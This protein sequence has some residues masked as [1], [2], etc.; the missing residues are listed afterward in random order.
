[1]QTLEQAILEL[2]QAWE[3]DA[4][5]DGEAP[6]IIGAVDETFLERLLLVFLDL[7]TGYLLLEEAVE[8]R[9]Y[10]TWKGLVDKRLETLGAP[11]RYLVSDRAKALIQL[12]E[13]G[14]E[15]LSIPDVFHLVHEIVKSYSLAIGRQLR[16][17]RQEWQ[18]AQD[19]LQKHQELE[20]RCPASP[21]ATCQVEATQA[22]VR[23][24]EAAQSEYRQ[25]LEILS[26]TLHPL[27]LDDSAPQTSTQVESRV[28]A[29]VEAIEALAHTQQLPERQAAMKKVKKQVPD[30]A[31]LVDFW[32]AGVRQDLEHAAV[33][34]RWR[35]WAQ[36]SLLPQVYW[37][38]QV[39]RT[40]CARRKTKMQ[41]ALEG[42]RTEFAQHA[43]TRCL[44]P[45]ALEH[46]Q[47]WATHQVHAF[48]RASSAVEGHNGS[49]AQMHHHQRGL[50]KQRYKV[51][52][53][54]HNFDGRAADGTT[55][56]VRFFRRP[57]PDLFET[58]LS[59]IGALPRPRQRKRVA[60]LST[61]TE[62]S[63][64]LSKGLPLV[65]LGMAEQKC[66]KICVQVLSC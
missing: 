23:R 17:A 62:I 50:P 18:K 14:L 40:R 24:W 49:L 58:V 26:L 63:H 52:A 48:Q 11:V 32:W 65:L 34:P 64:V 45:Q 19:G 25:R 6:E 59:H 8:D 9:S 3:Q 10:A 2:G 54:L 12:A 37:A 4:T 16:Q 33:S 5:A 61:W 15:C 53:V 56:A 44:P 36:E 31:A 60:V 29:Q 30:L 22:E 39:T 28:Y 47:A 7:P 41:Q 51:W 55:P 66:A 43:I 38:H 21:E 46:W 20:P 27:R 42:V 1:M 13:Q 35:K 57:F